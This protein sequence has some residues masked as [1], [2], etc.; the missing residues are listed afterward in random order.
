MIEL[1]KEKILTGT[2]VKALHAKFETLKQDYTKYNAIEYESF[3]S[4]M[5][6]TDLLDGSEYIF[7]EPMRGCSFY[8]DL[9]ESCV[10]PYERIS[11]EYDKVKKYFEAHKKKMSGTMLTEYTDLMDI[12]ERKMASTENTR[13]M[14]ETFHDNTHANDTFY[15]VGFN[16][17]DGVIEESG[18]NPIFSKKT[19]GLRLIDAIT[20]GVANPEKNGSSLYRYLTEEA[21]VTEPKTPKQYQLNAYTTNVVKRMM[22]DSYISEKVNALDNMNLRTLLKGLAKEDQSDFINSALMESHTVDDLMVSTGENSVNQIFDDLENRNIYDESE[23]VEKMHNLMCEKAIVAMNESFLAMDALYGV[24]AESTSNWDPIVEQ[25]CIESSSIE[26]IP[27]DI[28]EQVGMLKNLSEKIDSEYQVAYESYFKSNGDASR[29]VA[30]TTG[31]LPMYRPTKASEIKKD[32]QSLGSKN[33][34]DDTDDDDEDEDTPDTSSSAKSDEQRAADRDAA[35]ARQTAKYANMDISDFNFNEASEDE[36]EKDNKSGNATS[37]AK[38]SDEDVSA[39]PIEVEKPQKRP[40]FQ[41]IQ[42]RALDA[43]AKFHKHLSKLKRTSIDAKNAAKAT[44]KIPS[45]INGMIKKQIDDWEEMDDDRRKEYIIKPGS[46]KKVFRALK[47]AIEHGIAFAINPLLNIVLLIAQKLS[48]E[49]DI[50]I[51]NELVRELQAEKTVVNAKIE[52]MSG[53]P[54]MRNEKYRMMR[55]KDKLDAEIVRISANSNYV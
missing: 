4:E 47:I 6:L 10:I 24:T 20:L 44:G 36:D 15:N 48:H 17:Y 28:N 26:K 21:I 50:R 37:D 23:S 7:T 1:N 43:N 30:Q 16:R 11:E 35:K 33:D 40:F 13:M 2:P 42:N 9:M 39:K 54:K 46:R 53:D 29:V 8:K 25:L 5:A 52:D 51:R 34:E 41:R 3:Y 12:M 22:R 31:E 18:E 55:I 38:S 45:G 27:T 49:K 14:Y 32:D 19:K